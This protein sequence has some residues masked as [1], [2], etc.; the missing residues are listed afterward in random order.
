MTSSTHLTPTLIHLGDQMQKTKR[1]TTFSSPRNNNYSEENLGKMNKPSKKRRG[2]RE[3]EDTHRHTHTHMCTHAKMG[4][5]DIERTKAN[6]WV[7]VWAGFVCFTFSQF[8]SEKQ[9]RV[10]LFI[11]TSNGK[12][13]IVLILMSPL[14][15]LCAVFLAE[16]AEVSWGE[17]KFLRLSRGSCVILYKLLLFM[18]WVLFLKALLSPGRRR[19]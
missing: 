4:E 18:C 17:S 6:S 3:K 16:V 7:S 1:I 12:L 11:R 13:V 8:K 9:K 19:E 2:E 10:K 15:W 14:Q 5:T